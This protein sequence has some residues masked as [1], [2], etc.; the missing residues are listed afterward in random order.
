MV[1]Y[2]DEPPIKESIC[3]FCT[4]FSVVDEESTLTSLLHYL[5][6]LHSQAKATFLPLFRKK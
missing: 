6:I 2:A 4:F 5:A 1:I 3:L